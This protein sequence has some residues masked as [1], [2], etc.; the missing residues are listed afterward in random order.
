MRHIIDRPE[1]WNQRTYMAYNECATVYCLAGW[2]CV[3]AG[4]DVVALLRGPDG[5]CAVFHHAKRILGLSQ[6]QAE[7]LFLYEENARGEHPTVEEFA[8]RVERVTG[9]CLDT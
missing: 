4:L 3:L 1:H 6:S 7:A 5:C 8:A 9:V 2:T